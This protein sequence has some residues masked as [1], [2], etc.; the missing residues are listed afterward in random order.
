[1][2]TRNALI[3]SDVIDFREAILSFDE[4]I[5]GDE[6]LFV[7]EWYLQHREYLNNDGNAQVS[8]VEF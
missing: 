8:F 2:E 7:R 5:T 1:M 6:Y 4:L 3:T